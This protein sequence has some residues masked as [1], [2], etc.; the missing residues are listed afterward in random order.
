MS[1]LT[2]KILI[3]S[4]VICDPSLFIKYLMRPNIKVSFINKMRFYKYFKFILEDAKQIKS[5]DELTLNIEESY[6]INLKGGENYCF[7]DSKNK[8]PLIVIEIKET[9]NLLYV[10]IHPF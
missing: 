8:A 4:C 10:D 5:D 9:N 2:K 1:S 7:Y 6:E 3:T